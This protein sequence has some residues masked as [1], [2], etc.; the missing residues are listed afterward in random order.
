MSTI[1]VKIMKYLVGSREPVGAYEIGRVL[2]LHFNTVEKALE[3]FKNEGLAVVDENGHRDG[4][5]Y[6]PTEKGLAAG[7]I[8]DLFDDNTQ[9]I[10]EPLRKEIEAKNPGLFQSLVD[11]GLLHLEHR[12]LEVAVI[13]PKAQSGALQPAVSI[14]APQPS[15]V[16][17][18]NKPNNGPSNSTTQMVT[19]EGT[20][21]QDLNQSGTPGS[22][23]GEI[24]RF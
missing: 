4:T 16:G 10:L 9:A 8:L 20:L 18:V 11:A 7:K 6:Q 24:P 5:Y 13:N 3:A 1:R 22:S 14:A 12:V 17:T 23:A 21:V 19:K 15:I 2:N